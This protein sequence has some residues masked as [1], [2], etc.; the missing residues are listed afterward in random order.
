MVVEILVETTEVT[1]DSQL[2]E[3]YDQLQTTF[4][5]GFEEF[6][7]YGDPRAELLVIVNGKVIHV[8]S[9]NVCDD[10][11]FEKL[12]GKSSNSAKTKQI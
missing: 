10:W 3:Y 5:K 2:K 4:N 9:D 1:D 7:M 6:I 11:I 12:Y 8:N